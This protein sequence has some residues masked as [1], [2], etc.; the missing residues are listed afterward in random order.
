M[1]RQFSFLSSQERD[2]ARPRSP[3]YADVAHVRIAAVRTRVNAF[4]GARPR[5]PQKAFSRVVALR[6]CATSHGLGRRNR[7]L[8]ACSQGACARNC[9]TTWH[10]AALFCACSH[11]EHAQ[12]WIL[13]RPR[14]CDF[15]HVRIA[16]TRANGFPG[17][18]R[19][20]RQRHLR[21]CSKRA[22]ANTR[23]P[24]ACFRRLALRALCPKAWALI[25]G[26]TRYWGLEKLRLLPPFAKGKHARRN[27]F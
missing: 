21:A 23:A 19:G 8:C 24:K 3:Q 11:C 13:R 10:V 27:V 14:P 15:A 5:S 4:C 12:K 1:L 22:C 17:H 25:L 26:S 2:L 7:H 20:R 9:A 6:M 18:D 16:N